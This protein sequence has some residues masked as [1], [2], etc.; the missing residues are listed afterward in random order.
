MSQ[1]KCAVVLKII[2]IKKPYFKLL[3]GRT[4]T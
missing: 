3:T 4:D 1:D 2:I